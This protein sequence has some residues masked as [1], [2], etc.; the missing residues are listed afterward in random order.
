MRHWKVS[1][2]EIGLKRL[3]DAAKA[4][5]FGSFLGNRQEGAVHAEGFRCGFGKRSKEAVEI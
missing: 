1:Q 5:G 4:Q 3:K 2:K